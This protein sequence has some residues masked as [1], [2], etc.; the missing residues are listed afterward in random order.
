[1]NKINRINYIVQENPKGVSET[2]LTEGISPSS[3][4]EVLTNQTKQWIQKNGKTAVV[5]LLK[6]HP[7]KN[8]IL[9]A[10]Q[11][12]YDNYGG[13]GCKSSFDGSP[14]P[15]SSKSSFSEDNLSELKKMS[16]QELQA[17]YQDLKALLKQFPD[18]EQLLEEAKAAWQLIKPIVQ[19]SEEENVDKGSNQT[20]KQRDQADSKTVFSVTS[21]DLAVGSFIFGVALIISQI[22]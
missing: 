15:C 13:C 2:L 5:K 9:S 20:K 14:C 7:E 22:R 16:K 3:D 21:K 18:D 6:V 4:L 1:M 12:E 8:A 19:K 11:L 17:H 10:N